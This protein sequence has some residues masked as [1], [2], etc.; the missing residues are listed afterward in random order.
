MEEGYGGS[1]VYRVRAFGST[2]QLHYIT[3]T[4]DN[5]KAHLPPNGTVDVC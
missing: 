2:Q 5:R 4:L 3:F 1:Y